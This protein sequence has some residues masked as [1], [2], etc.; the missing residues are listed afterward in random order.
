MYTYYVSRLAYQGVRNA[1]FSENLAYVLN[2][3]PH[4]RPYY[5][6]AWL[7][8]DLTKCSIYFQIYV[9]HDFYMLL[10]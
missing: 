3:W 6:V 10:D 1:S 8:V 9:P 2:G 5:Q 7:S 4:C